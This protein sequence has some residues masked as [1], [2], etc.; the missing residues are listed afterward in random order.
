[1]FL[2]AIPVIGGILQKGL[3]IIDKCVP[4]KDLAE[5]LKQEYTLAAMNQ[6]YQAVANELDKRATIIAAEA[7]GQSFFQR[8]WR[9]ILML[10]FNYIIAHNYIIAPIFHLACVPVP[11][12]MW[13]LLQLGIGGYIVGRSVEK[14]AP[15]VIAML[16]KK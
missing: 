13:N 11:E 8:N 9:P 15:T 6:D 3:D 14:V 2:E 4:D 7:N 12:Q 1:M 16:G 10:T 5:K